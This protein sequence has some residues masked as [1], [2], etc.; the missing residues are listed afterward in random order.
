MYCQP[1]ID[2]VER[3]SK[4]IELVARLVSVLLSAG[5]HLHG[6]VVAHGVLGDAMRVEKID[7]T[8]A[9]LLVSV[10]PRILAVD[11]VTTIDEDVSSKFTCRSVTLRSGRSACIKLVLHAY[12]SGQNASTVSKLADFDF[13]N[14]SMSS[15]RLYYRGPQR[16]LVSMISRI[17]CKRFALSGSTVPGD[18]GD[19]A[20]WMHGA[21]KLLEAGWM[22][23]TYSGWVLARWGNLKTGSAAA[24]VRPVGRAIAIPREDSACPICHECFGD[25][26]IVA[27]L[28]CSHNIHAVCMGKGGMCAWLEA[29]HVTCPCC[30]ADVRSAC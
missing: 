19:H 9:P 21:L 23:E 28:E 1:V 15:S 14:L 27:N 4:H 25:S 30:R 13:Q 11:Y 26:D 24:L 20:R 6:D 2:E 5:A 12:A 22:M 8:V 17:G 29:G 7:A 18:A 16:N 10:I 3:R